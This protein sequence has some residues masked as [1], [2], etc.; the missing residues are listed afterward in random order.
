MND[1]THSHISELLGAY[2]LDA[3]DPDERLAVERHLP[4][5]EEC[6]AEVDGHLAVAALLADGGAAPSTALWGRIEAGITAAEA[7]EARVVPLPR[8]RS[9]V[10]PVAVAAAAALLVGLV[11]VQTARV[12]SLQTQLT[13]AEGRVEQLE[14]AI[15]SGTLETFAGELRDDPDLTRVALG[16]EDG[17]VSGTVILLPDGTGLL[18]DHELAPLPGDRTYQLWAIQDGRVISAGLLGSDP[19]VVAFHVDLERLDGLVITEEIAGG[20]AVSEQPP[21]AAWLADA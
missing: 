13:A 19:G 17:A 3:V 7:G 10:A 16:A 12:G 18:T 5:C 14:L 20:V 2:A 9:R 6:R 8:R 4:T 1:T 11:G 15:A 21:L